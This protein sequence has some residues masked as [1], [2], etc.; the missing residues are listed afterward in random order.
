MRTRTHLTTP[1]GQEPEAT[2]PTRSGDETYV[3]GLAIPEEPHVPGRFRRLWLVLGVVAVL[4]LIAFAVFRTA[5]AGQ[6]FDPALDPNFAP[7][8]ASVDDDA[9]I[10]GGSEEG[11]PGDG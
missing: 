9:P 4:A 10:E 1:P 8:E 6:T 2:A 3:P 11:L 7:G 5:T